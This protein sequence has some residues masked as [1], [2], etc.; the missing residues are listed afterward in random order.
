MNQFVAVIKTVPYK[1]RGVQLKLTS[2]DLFHSDG[3][4]CGVPRYVGG[5]EEA[6]ELLSLAGVSS[7]ELAEKR[8]DFDEGQ[9]VRIALSAD[10]ET[11]KVMGFN[12]LWWVPAPKLGPHV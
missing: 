5:Y 3:R 6:A 12:P 10:D 2:L 1:R 4:E 8:R 11:V 9:E 7:I